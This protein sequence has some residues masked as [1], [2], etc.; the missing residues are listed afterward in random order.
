MATRPSEVNSLPPAFADWFAARG[1]QPFPHQLEMLAAA[2]AGK[3]ALLVAPTGAGKTLAGFL[4]TLAELIARPQRGIHTLY[5]SPLK[6]LAVDIQRNLAT[7]VAEMGLQISLDSRTGDTTI[8]RRQRQRRRPPNILLTTPESLALMLSYH[9]TARTFAGLHAVVVDELHAL[10]DNK[11]GDLLA[12]GLARLAKLAPRARRVGLSATVA[13]APALAAYLSPSGRH[14]PTRVEVIRGP[15][16]AEPEI[17]ILIAGARLPWS[18]HMARYALPEVYELIRGAGTTIVFVNTRAQ[19]E[20]TFHELWRLNED[21]LAIALHHGSLGREQRKKVEG[22]MAAGTLRAIVATSS[23][24]LGVDWG[25]VDLVVQLGAPKGASRLLQRI[26]RSNH[27][28]DQPSRAVLVPGNRFEVLECR[29]AKEAVHARALDRAPSRPGALDVLA[30]HIWGTACAGPFAADAL[31]DEVTTAAPYA[32][33]SRTDFDDC[34]S[35][36]VDGG[37]ALKVYDRYKRL[38]CDRDGLYRLVRPAQARRYRMN[39]GVIVTLPMLKVR[40]GRGRVLGEVEEHFVRGLTPGDTFAFAGRI[41]RFERIRE[42]SVEV[43]RVTKAE[44]PRVPTYGGGRFPLTT[45]LADRVRAL[46]ADPENWPRFPE[47]V[48]EWLDLQRARSVLPHADGL[49]VETF[50]RGQK[51]FLVAYCFEGRNAHQTLGMLLTRRMER[52]GLGPLGFV[53]SDYA[54][55][56]WSLHPAEDMARLFDQD[57]MGDDLEAWMAESTLLKR[58]FRNCAVIAGLIERRHPGEELSGRQITF[59]ADLIYDVLRSHQPDHV[60][61][62]ATRADAAS[63]LTDIRRLSGMLARVKGKITHHR[64]DRVSP[65]AVPVLLSIG[66]EGVTGDAVD[67]LLD[68]SAQSLIQEAMGSEIESRRRRK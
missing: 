35:F 18:G 67:E 21:G 24:D 33:L 60:L 22:A 4:P 54:I 2:E 47:P 16:G 7:P 10:A 15:D 28:L 51:A 64:L 14:D 58:T 59:N 40:F 44:N 26:G 12:L 38:A 5:V 3:S 32:A 65:L 11:R 34:L 13:D 39:A 31:Y 17:D 62:R 61:L 68:E 1:W 49:L 8:A 19:A 52:A 20:I 48:R 25:A 41:L 9:D 46:I 63:G 23:L 6:A 53:A 37:Y 57:M 50:P 66:R 56:V 29:A 43:S 55:A 30:Q 45:N 27:R 36:V 42:L